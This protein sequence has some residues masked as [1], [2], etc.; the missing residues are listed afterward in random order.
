MYLVNIDIFEL[1]AKPQTFE[2]WQSF[3]HEMF[4]FC[5]IMP[6][7]ECDRQCPS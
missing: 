1:F 2:V 5:I 3:R 6:H 4:D 7:V